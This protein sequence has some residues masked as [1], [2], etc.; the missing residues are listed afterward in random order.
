MKLEEIT[1][2]IASAAGLYLEA[3]AATPTSS[4]SEEI[5]VELEAI[6]RSNISFS[7]VSVELEPNNS[8]L[9]PNQVLENNRPW[10]KK[11]L[12]KL[13]E[14]TGITTPYWLYNKGG[15]GLYEVE[16]QRNIGL[17]ETPA[18]AKAKFI[19]KING[20]E[21]PF[22]RS[23]VYK[24]NDPVKGEVYQPFE[25]VPPVSV[26]FREKVVIIS[27]EKNTIVPVTI[28]AGKDSISGNITF[29]QSKN[30]K[31]EP[32]RH[33]FKINNKGGSVTV[34]FNI[35]PP[36]VQDETIL[37]PVINLN[38]KEYSGEIIKIDYNHIPLQTLVVPAEIKL[39][40][41]KIAKKGEN[42][43]YIAGA[44]DV[45]PSSLEQI[46]YIVSEVDPASITPASLE[47]FDAVVLGI[48]AY[49]T[50]EE[51]KFT[52]PS[53]LKYVENGGTVIVQYNV[54]NGLVVN[55]IAPYNLNISRERVTEEDAEIRFLAP[56]HPI[57]NTP[58]KITSADFE[59]WVQERG[60]YFA[61]SW[62]EE[63]TPVLSMN[64]TNEAPKEGS[65]LVARHGKGYFIYTGLSF[66]RQFPEGVSG[67][68]R[69]FA[70]MVSLG[71]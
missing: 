35:T 40:K 22:I 36:P 16:D 13:P 31:I 1:E 21:I 15:L 7:L 58:N 53:V 8:S 37:S 62:A 45:V 68:Y 6:N 18:K 61:N 50:V 2:I 71:N 56:D 27:E 10:K 63:F 47:K 70:N 41:L 28:T 29:K 55:Q 60:L 54:S 42:I 52:Q 3:L 64:D 4:P 44:G 12:L 49:N 46:G 38:E 30:W 65:L 14:N 23:V 33:N 9:E 51:L 17:P 26:K 66:F 11:L 20:V 69:L 57:L 39:V 24:Y 34:N 32:Q 25:I 5:E 67:A 48:R 59:G 43:G 19:F